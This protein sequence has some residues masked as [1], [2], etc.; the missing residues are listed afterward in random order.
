MAM[1]GRWLQLL[2]QAQVCCPSTCVSPCAAHAEMHTSLQRW[3]CVL[4][5]CPAS[6]YRYAPLLHHGLTAW[7]WP[8]GPTKLVPHAAAMHL[9]LVL[10][11]WS[12]YAYHACSHPL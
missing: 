10:P 4:A 7:K 2:A 3:L 1:L 12:C 6:R 9:I 5:M 11:V 8:W